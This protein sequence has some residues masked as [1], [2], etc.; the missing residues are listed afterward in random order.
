MSAAWSLV[1]EI[2]LNENQKT[3]RLFFTFIIKYAHAYNKYLNLSGDLQSHSTFWVELLLLLVGP[4]SLCELTSGKLRN[5]QTIR[6]C[7]APPY[8]AIINDKSLFH[9]AQLLQE[10]TRIH[11]DIL[12]LA[13]VILIN[14]NVVPEISDA[15]VSLFV[16]FLFFKLPVRLTYEMRRRNFSNL[17]IRAASFFSSDSENERIRGCTVC[18]LWNDFGKVAS[19]MY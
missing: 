2:F 6:F 5:K 11:V 18:S 12:V 19:T 13:L 10:K 16:A 15:S 17:V 3:F 7:I 1:S 8:S 9:S 14:R 4:C